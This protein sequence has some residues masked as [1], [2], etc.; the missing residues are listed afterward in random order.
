MGS[1]KRYTNSLNTVCLT[2]AKELSAA[3]YL[4]RSC[5]LGRLEWRINFD[6]AETIERTNA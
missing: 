1:R 6:S 2:V 5:K 3:Q 4:A